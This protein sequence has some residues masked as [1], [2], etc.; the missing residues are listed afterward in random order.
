MD[1]NWIIVICDE[2]SISMRKSYNDVYTNKTVI[3]RNKVLSFHFLGQYI[4]K[5][6]RMAYNTISFYDGG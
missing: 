5:I 3:Q 6:Y 2:V 4:L 1:K